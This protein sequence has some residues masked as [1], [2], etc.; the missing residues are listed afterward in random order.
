MYYN[1][2]SNNFGFECTTFLGFWSTPVHDAMLL[3]KFLDCAK[4]LIQC[5]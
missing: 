5:P 1:N 2:A 4:V 3:G